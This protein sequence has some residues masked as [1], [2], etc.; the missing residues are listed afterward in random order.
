MAHRQ[1][2]APRGTYDLFVVLLPMLPPA[3][4]RRSPLAITAPLAGREIEQRTNQAPKR[5]AAEL[6]S[7]SMQFQPPEYLS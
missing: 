3:R 5:V 6:T 2:A 4:S 1:I 7:G